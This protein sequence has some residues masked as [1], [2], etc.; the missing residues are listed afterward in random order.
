MIVLGVF[1]VFIVAAM[2]FLA[3]YKSSSSTTESPTITVWGTIPANTFQD[4]LTEI[5]LATGYTYNISYVEKNEKNFIPDFIATLA[6][7][8]SPDA[9]FVPLD[10]AVS[11]RDKFVTIPFTSYPLDTY[12]NDFIQIGE[13]LVTNDG[14]V[15][16]PFS[17]DP[18]I[19]Y[20]NR[21]MFNKAGIADYPKNWQEVSALIPKLTVKNS[22]SITKSAIALGEYRNINNAK[23]ILSTMIM[24]SG[25]PIVYR[26]SEDMAT[27][28][29]GS[30]DMSDYTT[31]AFKYFA[32]FSDPSSANYSWN[33]SLKN[34]QSMFTSGNLA[35]YLGF[36]SE[37]SSIRDKNPSLNFD[38]AP[39]PQVKDSN[40]ETT[41]GKLMIIAF[42]KMSVNTTTAFTVLSDFISSDLI[43][44]WSKKVYL[45]PVKRDLI[46][47]GTK[48]PYM[49][50]FYREALISNAWLDPN[51]SATETIFKN[52]IE[53]YT[54]GIK[55]ANDVISTAGLEI[56]A[57]ISNN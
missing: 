12:K 6:R 53:N 50:V 7:G 42:P 44:I 47:A 16:L 29:S 51:K 1:G 48:D 21:D 40:K 49:A 26:T 20:W 14:M 45:P 37:L 43:S 35:M 54:S 32:D 39:V 8:Q 15:G 46:S 55:T 10:I 2:A 9:V 52:M 33:R 41:F 24:Q 19:M 30:N 3:T 13:Q 5:N 57:L 36:A 17:I 11:Q 23:E 27:S 34:S 28:L 4:Y 22:S 38:M 56:S 31:A 18:L 25:N